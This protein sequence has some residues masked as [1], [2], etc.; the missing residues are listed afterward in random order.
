MKHAKWLCALALVGCDD[1]DVEL[2]EDEGVVL[3]AEDEVQNAIIVSDSELR[4]VCDLAGLDS[5]PP[6]DGPDQ[7]TDE[8]DPALGTCSTGSNDYVP[9][10][11]GCGSCR[12]P[13]TGESGR[14]VEHWWQYCY[15]PPSPPA[16]GCFPKTLSFWSCELGC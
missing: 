5:Q 1:P 16:C 9:V 7:F 12:H 8:A 11:H 14:K 6:L 13:T 2:A 4:E 15:K 10:D 3:A